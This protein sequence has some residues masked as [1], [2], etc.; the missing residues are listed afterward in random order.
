MN[1]FASIAVASV[2]T[3]LAGTA[4]VTGAAASGVF[5]AS[6]GGDDGQRPRADQQSVTADGQALMGVPA[7]STNDGGAATATMD[8]DGTPDQGPGDFPFGDDDRIEGH[9]GHGHDDDGV[10]DDD[11]RGRDHEE[12]DDRSGHSEHDDDDDD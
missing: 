3:V 7:G 9:D 8:D 2:A 1:R 12:D 4:I 10:D 6:D 5:G 11:H